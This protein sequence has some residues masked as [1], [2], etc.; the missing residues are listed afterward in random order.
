MGQGVSS[1]LLT[2]GV[3]A[4]A[5]A[6]VGGFLLLDGR[7]QF[8]KSREAKLSMLGALLEALLKVYGLDSASEDKWNDYEFVLRYETCCCR[9]VAESLAFPS[10]VRRR[11]SYPDGVRTV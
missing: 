1:K 11:L 7:L 9:A 6:G 5:G 2:L 4:G 8:E 3:L 10:L